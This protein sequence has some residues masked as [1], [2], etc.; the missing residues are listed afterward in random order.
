MET[1]EVLTT[2][3]LHHVI[4][5]PVNSFMELVWILADMILLLTACRLM[6]RA[7]LNEMLRRRAKI[8]GPT[9]LIS[10]QQLY[11][12]AFKLLLVPLLFTDWWIEIREIPRHPLGSAALIIIAVLAALLAVLDEVTTARLSVEFDP[13]HVSL[14]KR[15]KE[16]ES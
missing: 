7:V 12:A 15:L 2:L 11:H 16:F 6:N 8:N 9:V 3:I 10:Y 14:S 5:Q 13:E 4:H 1:F